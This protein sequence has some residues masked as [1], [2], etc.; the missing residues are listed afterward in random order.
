MASDLA[1]EIFR[2][3]FEEIGYTQRRKNYFFKDVG[4]GFSKGLGLEI[5]RTPLGLEL[6]PAVFVSNPSAGQLIWDSLDRAEPKF[7]RP[8]SEKFFDSMLEFSNLSNVLRKI[9]KPEHPYGFIAPETGDLTSVTNTIVKDFLVAD[10]HYLGNLD[11]CGTLIEH[12]EREGNLG[13]LLDANRLMAL[14]SL[15][16]PK[17]E[18]ITKLDHLATR[19]GSSLTPQLIEFFKDFVASK[20]PRR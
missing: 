5:R 11:S 14:Y 2:S 16:L 4:E 7:K 8:K 15:C 3:A 18:A 12:L 19:C 20:E 1:N 6:D 10:E 9:D 13:M 17:E